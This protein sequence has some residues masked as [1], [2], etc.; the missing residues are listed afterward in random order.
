LATASIVTAKT[1]P[2]TADKQRAQRRYPRLGWWRGRTAGSLPAVTDYAPAYYD[3]LDTEHIT[4]MICQE[5]ERQPLVPLDPLVGGFQGSG[6]YAIYYNGRTVPLYRPLTGTRI[7][8]YAGQALSHN[9][10]TGVAVR[11]RRPLWGRLRNHHAS[12]GGSD[13]SAAEFGVRLLC[14]PDVHADLGE[15]GLRV[16]Y[17]PVWNAI[18]SGFGGHEQGPTT[19]QSARSKWDTVH[20]GRNR[21]FGADKHDRA[22]LIRAVGK[23]IAV[24][25]ASYQNAPWHRP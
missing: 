18:L 1:V 8:V 21:T 19:R 13:L 9:S 7:P 12:I 3:P 2:R 16:F 17:K 23:H 25:I 15:N 4:A 10:A 6:L 11:A 5:L 20:P 14:L 22:E 24:Q